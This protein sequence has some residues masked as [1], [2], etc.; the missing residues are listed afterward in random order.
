[1]SSELFE[2][3]EGHARRL[4]RRRARGRDARR[5]AV[6]DRGA[7]GVRLARARGRSASATPRT[8]CAARTRRSCSTARSAIA[9]HLFFGTYLDPSVHGTKLTLRLDLYSYHNQIRH[10]YANPVDDPTNFAVA[11]TS[12][13]TFLDAGVLVGWHVRVV[14]G[15]RR[16]AARRVRLLS[17]RARRQHRQHARCRDP[18]PTAGTSPMQARVTI[19]HRVNR[20]GVTQRRVRAG[21]GS[22]RACRGST[23]YEL[24]RR[25]WARAYYS[26]KFFEEHELELRGL[27]E[28]RSS[29]AVAR[30]AHARRRPICAATPPISFAATAARSGASSTRCRYSSHAA[31][32]RRSRFARSASAT[33]ATSSSTSRRSDAASRLSAGRARR[34]APGFATTSASAC[35][36]TSSPSCCRCSASTSATASRATAPRSTSSSA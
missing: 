16:A 26:W 31:A 12:T 3:V 23:R 6:V 14:A 15:P 18:K 13:E 24:P 32:D 17:R 19:D 28:R 33:P 10:E 22:S 1:M 21:L 5:Q 4:A 20:F 29:P 9:R 34:R 25:R 36:S 11:R 7:D 30:G 35:A 2:S 8:I 27:R